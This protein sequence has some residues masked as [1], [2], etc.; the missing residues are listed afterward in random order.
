MFD[1]DRIKSAA[2]KYKYETALET[3]SLRISYRELLNMI[4]AVYNSLCV[5]NVTGGAVAVL[6]RSCAASVCSSFA[7]DRAG[8]ECITADS[9]ISEA[10]A[11]RLAEKYRP[12]V[13][14]MPYSQLLRLA[15]VFLRFGCRTAVLTEIPSQNGG[16]ENN[17]MFP[18][19]FEFDSL[20]EKNDYTFVDKDRGGRRFE[21]VFFSG[22][23]CDGKY[24]DTMPDGIANLPP[25]TPVYIDL[26]LYEHAGAVAVTSLLYGGR[27]CF[28]TDMPDKKLFKRKKVGAVICDRLSAEAYRDFPCKILTAET[29]PRRP[30]LYVGGGLFCLKDINARLSVISG[31]NAVCEFDGCRLR[32]IFETDSVPDMQSTYVKRLAADC[33][34]LLSA[35][36]V[37]KSFVFRKKTV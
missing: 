26:P 10:A 7:C 36:N 23:D 6:L 18:A 16:I 21:H 28:L 31:M 4:D 15:D 3:Q 34:R 33:R 8:F 11:E 17:Q 32:I 27:R 9:L 12:S 30:F 24:I 35:Y 22:G 14:I 25:R 37:P 5:M 1:Y 19:Q 13:V 2:Y 29:D 20:L